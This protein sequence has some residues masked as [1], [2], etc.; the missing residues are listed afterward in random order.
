MAKP[1]LTTVALDPSPFRAGLAL[2]LAAALATPSAAAVAPSLLRAR[3]NADILSSDPGT[4]RDENTDAVLLHVV[5]GL[6]AVREDTSIGPLLASRWTVAPDGKTYVFQLRPGIVFHNGA[7]LTSAD[8]VWS[9]NRYLDP[10]TRWRCLSDLSKGGLAEVTAVTAHGPLTVSISLDR[11]APLFLKTLARADCGGTGILQRA[12]VDPHGAWVAPIGTGPFRFAAWKRN[13]YIELRRFDRYQARPGP[14]DGNTGGKTAAVDTVRFL[15]IPDGSAARAALLRGE[16]D[17]LDN[18]NPVELA[19]L[20]GKSGVRIQSAPSDDLYALLLQTRD[21][22]LRDPR[23][24]RALAISLDTAALTRAITRGEGRPDS[25]PVPS[26]SPF[27][28]PVESAPIRPDLAQARRLLTACGYRG[29]AIKLA[30]NQRYPLMFD[31][32]VVIQAMAKQA[33]INFEIETLDWATQLARYAAGDYQ[34]MTFGYSAR[35]DPSL[36]F[37]SLIGDKAKDPRKVWDTPAARRLLDRSMAEADPV[38]R[39]AV[40]DDLTRAWRQDTPSVVLFNSGRITALRSTVS[41]YRSWPAQQQ[42]LWGV[43]VN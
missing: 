36:T 38:R 30:T 31:S 19:A 34:A 7:P 16:L 35:L 13:Q 24:R 2:A 27:Y 4:R 42:R 21:P 28:G 11:P 25:G 40:F 5:E 23:F 12:S 10:K 17:V 39:Q 22:L 1:S 43:A 8:V 37:A 20:R 18:L 29:Q 6:V 3:L 9:L 15:V 41:G 33:G 32:A 26:P 14:P